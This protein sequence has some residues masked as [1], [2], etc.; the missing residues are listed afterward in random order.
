MHKLS[1]WDFGKEIFRKENLWNWKI[2]KLKI[3]ETETYWKEILK[4]KFW[5]RSFE[6]EILKQKFW[7]RKSEKKRMKKNSQK[8]DPPEFI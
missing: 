7:K 4:L 3:I 2:L 5:N 1:N 8:F 6:I